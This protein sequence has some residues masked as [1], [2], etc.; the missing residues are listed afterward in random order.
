MADGTPKD[1]RRHERVSVEIWVE[2][3]RGRELYYLRAANLSRGGVFLEN[4]IPH[5]YGTLVELEFTLPG[6][7]E[8]L[9]VRGRV[10]DRPEMADRLGMAVEFIEMEPAVARKIEEFVEAGPPI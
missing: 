2:E 8:R 9:H 6:D 7:R 1:R 10:V 3:T 4:T 5:P